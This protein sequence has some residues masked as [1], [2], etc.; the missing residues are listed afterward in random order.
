MHY[1]CALFK[2]SPNDVHFGMFE[3]ITFLC[4]LK[5]GLM[6]SYILFFCVFNAVH[7][8]IPSPFSKERG[9]Y[10]LPNGKRNLG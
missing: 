6:Y 1:K 9:C 5:M 3:R 8:F 2:I 4:P 7:N 10:L